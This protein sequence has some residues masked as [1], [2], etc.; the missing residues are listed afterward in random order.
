MLNKQEKRRTSRRRKRINRGARRRN[1]IRISVF[2]LVFVLAIVGALS[3]GKSFISKEEELVQEPRSNIGGDVITEAKVTEVITEETEALN[4]GEISEK[5][6]GF[7]SKLQKFYQA[8]DIITVYSSTN[9]RQDTVMVLEPGSYIATYG[10]ENNWI[11]I[12]H[13]NKEGYIKNENL[14]EIEDP[15]MFK[16]IDGILVVNQEFYLPEDYEPEM[17]KRALDSFELM[18]EEMQR[19]DMDIK[20]VSEFR[21]F[22]YQKNLYNNDLENYGEEYVNSYTAK[23]GHSEHQT[24][25][26]ID[27]GLANGPNGVSKDFGETREAEWLEANSYKYGFILRYPRG[28]DGATGYAFEPWHF[29][30]VGAE[31]AKKIYESGLSLEE[32]YGI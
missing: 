4:P 12:S 23:P 7:S 5:K 10:M 19:L 16:V 3:L 25:L 2:S 11:K 28:K 8:Q 22:D 29:R 1:R 27:L 13:N 15:N 17:S 32:Y 14:G 31:T 30:Y 26:A 20:I 24:G 21:S 18:K 6:E 9:D